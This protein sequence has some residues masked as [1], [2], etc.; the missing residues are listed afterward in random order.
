MGSLKSEIH[1]AAAAVSVTVEG[2]C[3][4]YFSR[5]DVGLECCYRDVYLHA[6]CDLHL[7]HLDLKGLVQ[8][9]FDTSWFKLLTGSVL[10]Q[11]TDSLNHKL[12]AVSIVCVK[13]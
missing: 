1:L 5:E 2:H 8:I 11:E 10:E 9:S 4:M 7:D 6:N 12:L 3:G 13:M